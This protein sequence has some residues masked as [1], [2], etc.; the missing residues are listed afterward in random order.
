MTIQ[1][2]HSAS[3]GSSSNLAWRVWTTIP[4]RWF[5]WVAPYRDAVIGALA[6]SAA[7]NYTLIG[8]AK[9][10]T[11]LATAYGIWLD[12]LCYDFLR[13]TLTRGGLQD[14]AF[15]ALIR[16]TILQERV[17]RAGMIAAVTKLTGSAPWLFEPWNTGDTGAYGNSAR[18]LICGGQFGYGVGRGGYGSMHL[19]A[20]AFMQIHRT[21]PSGVPSVDGY[22][23]T[24]GGYGGGSIEYVGNTTQLAGIT[25]DLIETLVNITKPTGSIMW[26]AFTP[27]AEILTSD[28][29]L[30]LTDDSG[31][32]LTNI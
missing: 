23:G 19:P 32:T 18:G 1:D 15:R 21:T 30:T 9:A 24:I 7:W 17:T 16:A 12:I 27:A 11:R 22:V 31:H 14:D 13:G 6:D 5:S 8:Y 28:A 3:I 26:I 20:Q 25:D 2:G 29:G 4:K 10:Q